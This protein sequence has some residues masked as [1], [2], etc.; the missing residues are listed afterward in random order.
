MV[1]LSSARAHLIRFECTRYIDFMGVS[2]RG[3]VLVLGAGVIGLTTALCLRRRGFDVVLVADRFAPDITSVVAGALWEW[4]PAV[5]GHHRD[6]FSRTKLWA[7]ESYR[8]FTELAETPVTGAFVRP[9][10]F[11]FRGRI[12]D[13]PFQYDKMKELS[14]VVR[15]FRHDPALITEHGVNA[16]VG[17]RDAYT[18]LAPM[19]DTDAYLP[20]LLDAAR[21]AGCR[22]VKRT[23]EPP[24]RERESDLLREFEAKTIV[25]C[26]GFGA[27]DLGDDTVYPLRGAVIRVCN[28]GRRMPRIQ[29]AHC[30]SHDGASVDPGFVFIVPRGRDRL[31]LGGFAEPHQTSLDIGLHN[32]EPVREVLRRCIEFMPALR[33]AEVDAMEPVRVGLRPARKENVRLEREPG[34]RIVHNYG[35]SGSGVT[36]SWGCA[37]EVVKMLEAD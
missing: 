25:N 32:H 13:S 37:A 14:R 15:G 16:T 31:I 27:R 1:D 34:C 10:T 8:I 19:I 11:Y 33:E 30:I 17:L 4:P 26:T 29:E 23:I 7:E 9:V 12:E 36:F 22:I 3:R 5:C 21:A 18:H 24:L 20:W 35:H 28:D 6:P 2:L